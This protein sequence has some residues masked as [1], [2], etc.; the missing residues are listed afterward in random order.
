[1]LLEIVEKTSNNVFV[2]LTVGG[3][4]RTLDDAYKL[5]KV[6]ADKI[7]INT[8]AVKN[9]ELISQIAEKFGKQCIVASI[10]AKKKKE[11]KWEAYIDSA[12]EP[13]GINVFGE[14]F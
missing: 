3:G 11:N 10:D 1:M 13:T 4:V 6:G 5:L 8:G 7:A 12:R 14:G 2:P 9:T